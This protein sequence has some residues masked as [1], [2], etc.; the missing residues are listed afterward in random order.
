MKKIIINIFIKHI[1][2]E[3]KANIKISLK[4]YLLSYEQFKFFIIKKDGNRMRW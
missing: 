3:I 2:L 4:T 1:K